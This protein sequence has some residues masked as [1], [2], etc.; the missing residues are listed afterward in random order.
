MKAEAV[1]SDAVDAS[2]G[3]GVPVKAGPRAVGVAFLQR[4]L[5]QNTR[6]AAVSELARHI[7]CDRPAAHRTLSVTGRI[8]SPGRAIRPAGVA[9]S[10]AAPPAP[11]TKS[12]CHS[13]PLGRW[14]GARIGSR[15]ATA[16]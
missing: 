3:C 4:S 9:F 5:V 8:Q 1:A 15:S 16:I 2:C 13:D 6:A 14:P 10:S 7:R 12:V 11:P